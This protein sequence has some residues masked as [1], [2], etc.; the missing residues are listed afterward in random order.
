MAQ[1]SDELMGKEAA[2]REHIPVTPG[3][4]D[5]PSFQ[6]AAAVEKLAK[7]IRWARREVDI[8]VSA[9]REK[10]TPRHMRRIAIE[11]VREVMARPEGRKR[12]ILLLS[13]VAFAA[14][15]AVIAVARLRKAHR[16]AITAKS[17][18]GYG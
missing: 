3:F 13:G 12:A 10:L 14:A 15:A 6:D 18:Y 2:D 8:T 1:T 4:T 7:E 5:L 11:K 17:T 9:L 16:N